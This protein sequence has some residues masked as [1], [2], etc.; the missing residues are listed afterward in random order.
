MIGD[1]IRCPQCSQEIAKEA[2]M[3]DDSEITMLYYC[4]KCGNW[5]QADYE[6]VLKGIN[7]SHSPFA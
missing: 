5:W 6:V 2:Q 4:E 1:T 3:T 7:R